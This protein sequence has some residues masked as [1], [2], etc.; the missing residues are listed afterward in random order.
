MKMRKQQQVSICEIMNL[1]IILINAV[2][3]AYT[4]PTD[5][6]NDNVKKEDDRDGHF[7]MRN[8]NGHIVNKDNKSICK[9]LGGTMLTGT[10]VVGII[11]IVFF[12]GPG[13]KFPFEGTCA[14]NFP[15]IITFLF[16]VTCMEYICACLGTFLSK[17]CMCKF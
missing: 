11:A 4:T 12:Y 5:S 6:R 8:A 2:L 13:L 7:S 1:I 14:S 10:V 9:V 3:I 17:L 16:T 15:V